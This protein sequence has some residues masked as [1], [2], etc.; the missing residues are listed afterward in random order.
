MERRVRH[1]RENLWARLPAGLTLEAGVGTGRNLPY[2]PAGRDVVGL[3]ISPRM[4]ERARRK[5][6]RSGSR[7]ALELGDVQRLPHADGT[8][9]AAVDRPG[10]RTAR[11]RPDRKRKHITSAGGQRLLLHASVQERRPSRRYIAEAERTVRDLVDRSTWVE[12]CGRCHIAQPT[13]KYEHAGEEVAMEQ[14]DAPDHDFGS[15][16][17]HHRQPGAPARETRLAEL[18]RLVGSA[19]LD[20]ARIPVVVTATDLRSGGRVDLRT[21]HAVEAIFASGALAGVLP[22]LERGGLM[23]ADGA[24]TSRVNTRPRS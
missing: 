15:R 22:P 18:R 21:G 23:L 24:S 19:R 6:G 1:W 4:L 9:D 16:L 3:D 7:V 8:F 20:R 14:R 5:P 12:G 11:W 13:N 17:A 10:A 2:Y